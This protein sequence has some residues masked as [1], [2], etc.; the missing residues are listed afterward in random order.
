MQDS[1]D[2]IILEVEDGTKAP[3]GNIKTF[4]DTLSK[5]GD[6]TKTTVSGLT[7]LKNKFD[8]ILGMRSE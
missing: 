8:I 7:D 6:K 4:V 5:L 1:L 2:K 3:S